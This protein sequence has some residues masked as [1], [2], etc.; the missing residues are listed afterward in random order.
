MTLSSDRGNPGTKGVEAE[1]DPVDLACLF[2]TVSRSRYSQW[3]RICSDTE[4]H[5]H[6]RGTRI[7]LLLAHLAFGDPVLTVNC[8]KCVA[9]SITFDK[10]S[11]SCGVVNR[12]RNCVRIVMLS[13][14]MHNVRIFLV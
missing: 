11:A 13:V 2:L 6:V 8:G 14:C 9:F 7:S 12:S 4:A 3:P 10:W 5:R 1:E